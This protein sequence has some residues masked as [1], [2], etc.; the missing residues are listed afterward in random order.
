[1]KAM[2][3]EAQVLDT[4]SMVLSASTNITISDCNQWIG[5]NLLLSTIQYRMQ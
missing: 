3:K 2:E 1:M 5:D 4:Q